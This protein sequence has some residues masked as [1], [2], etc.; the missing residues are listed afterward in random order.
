[1]R[2]PA[3]KYRIIQVGICLYLRTGENEFE[4][5]PYNIYVFPRENFGFSPQI[6]IDSSAADFNTQHKMDWNA[7]FREGKSFFSGDRKSNIMQ[8]SLI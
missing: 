2:T 1:M 5:R 3:T 7:W 8:V 4:A 6:A